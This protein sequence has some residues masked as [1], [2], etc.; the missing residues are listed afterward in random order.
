MRLVLSAIALI[1][2]NLLALQ[3]LLPL[4]EEI[5]FQLSA[6]LSIGLIYETYIHLC[7]SDNI[8]RPKVKSAPDLT[9]ES[10][11]PAEELSRIKLLEAERDEL[12]QRNAKLSI[13]QREIQDLLETAKSQLSAIENSISQVRRSATDNI[14]STNNAVSVFLSVLQEKG[15]LIDF[16]MEDIASISDTQLGTVARVVH[17][18]CRQ[19]LKEY[20]LISHICTSKEGERIRLERDFDA[21]CYKLVGKVAGE[22]PFCGVLLHRGWK[23]DKFNLP[24]VNKAPEKSNTPYIIVP[25]EVDML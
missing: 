18:G 20:L 2:F 9:Q 1:V 22:P 4:S 17:E 10:A 21:L 14:D 7:S 23:I 15:R 24:E 12:R 11:P 19:V 8:I 6:I 5:L 25:A 16:L 3:G 13:K